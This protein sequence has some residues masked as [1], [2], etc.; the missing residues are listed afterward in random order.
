MP[1][2]RNGRMEDWEKDSEVQEYGSTEWNMRNTKEAK[3]IS[4]SPSGR[5]SVGLLAA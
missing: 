1:I 2:R 3:G 5:S 4:A